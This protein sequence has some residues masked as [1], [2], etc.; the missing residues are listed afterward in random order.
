[1]IQSAPDS[2]Q[3]LVPCCAAGGGPFGTVVNSGH[4]VTYSNIIHTTGP[5]FQVS[6]LTRSSI[7]P[8]QV[9]GPYRRAPRKTGHAHKPRGGGRSRASRRLPPR[10]EESTVTRVPERVGTG[11]AFPWGGVTG[12]TRKS[13][14]PVPP[15]PDLAGKRAGSPRFP[16]RPESGIGKSPVSRLAANLSPAGN[17]GCDTL[18]V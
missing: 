1:M 18:R 13:P 12:Q 6:A 17:R 15:I 7:D 14:I 16:T 9:V 11:R 3:C 2:S 8:S 10:I 4:L 5:R